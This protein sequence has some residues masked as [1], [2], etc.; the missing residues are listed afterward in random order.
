[1]TFK[2]SILFLCIFALCSSCAN[3]MSLTKCPD[4]R[5]QEQKVSSIKRLKTNAKSKERLFNRKK[6]SEEAI[7]ERVEKKTL[8]RLNRIKL[9]SSRTFRNSDEKPDVDLIVSTIASLIKD[10]PSSLQ[11]KLQHTDDDCDI[12]YPYEQSEISCIVKEITDTQVKF[13]M[14]DNQDGPVLAIDRSDIRLLKYSDGRMRV[15]DMGTRDDRA[16]DSTDSKKEDQ[17]ELDSNE[18]SSIR[19]DNEESLSRNEYQNEFELDK[20]STI[21]LIAGILGF[22][23][24]IVPGIFMIPFVGLLGLAGFILALVFGNQV[25]RRATKKTKDDTLLKAKI[26]AIL[27]YVGIGLYAL[28]V[29]IVLAVLIIF[30]ASL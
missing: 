6:H 8:K 13:V 19:S 17:D 20:R 27:G 16:Y 24:T 30:L 21:S 15:V 5:G 3:Q 23:L 9:L 28:S 4:F 1:M 18:E 7:A 29:I 25:K 14:C 11:D 26:G 22:V 12:L 2:Q 10:R